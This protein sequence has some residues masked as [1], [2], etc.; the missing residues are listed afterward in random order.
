MRPQ[1]CFLVFLL[2]SRITQSKNTIAVFEA[3]VT[4]Q[5]ATSLHAS[6]AKVAFLGC[7]QL[8]GD[9]VNPRDQSWK[10]RQVTQETKQSQKKK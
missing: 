5:F 2:C 6:Q 8:S 3:L 7:Q 1:M 9:G 10:R 4:S